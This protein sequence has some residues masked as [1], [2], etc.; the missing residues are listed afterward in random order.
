[1]SHKPFSFYCSPQSPPHNSKPPTFLQPAAA[2][3]H[4]HEQRGLG[5]PRPSYRRRPLRQETYHPSFIHSLLFSDRVPFLRSAT[6]AGGLHGWWG[7]RRQRA[8]PVALRPYLD[9]AS[10]APLSDSA[11]QLRSMEAKMGRFFESVGNF[12]IGGNNI[13]WRNR[14][15]IAVYAPLLLMNFSNT[16]G[17][18]QGTET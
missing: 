10:G 2:H 8:R 3:H 9:A 16:H 14:D 17:G 5:L 13:P 4:H 18:E 11:D 12:F 7:P 1:S 15:I 6:D